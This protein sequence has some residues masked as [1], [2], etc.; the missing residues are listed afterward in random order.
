MHV[1][2]KS[3]VNMEHLF[4]MGH[5]TEAYMYVTNANMHFTEA[6]MHVTD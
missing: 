5:V 3:H 2:K 4:L 6:N 1:E